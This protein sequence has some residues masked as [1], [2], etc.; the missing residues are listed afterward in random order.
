MKRNAILLI[1][2]SV[3]AIW[4][5]G[6]I[7]SHSP[8]D[9]LVTIK[10]GDSQKFS[11]QGFANGPYT[12]TKN[13][14]IVGNA[15]ASFT[16]DAVL[17]DLGTFS[18]KVS[19]KDSFNVT[20][21]F[22][23]TV[24]V[25][26]DLPPVANAGPDQNLIYPNPV[27]LDGSASLDPEG[28]PLNYVWEIVG[29]P[30]GSSAGLDDPNAENPIFVP[31]K[32]GA[33][34]IVLIVNDGRLTSTP[35]TVIINSYVGYAP[36]I[37]DAGID[38][39]VLFGS[40]VTLDGSNSSDPAEAELTYSWKIDS[41]P[42]E[43][44]ATLDDPTAQKP[45]FIPDKKGVYVVSLIV[46]NTVYNS[47]IDLVVIVV[48]NNP[49]IANAG[50]DTTIADLGGSTTLN[51]TESSDPDGTA[52]EYTWTIIS[53]PYGSTA[54]LS[55]P[56]IATP[57]FTP[58]KKGSYIMKL[59]VS[60]GDLLSN[61]D[62]VIVT[63][64][65][66]VPTA[67]AGDPIYL[68]LGETAQLNGSASDPDSDPMTYLWTITS[69]PSG[70]TAALSDATI[71]NPTFTPDVQGSYVFSLVATDNTG[72]ASAPSTVVISTNNHQPVADAGADVIMASNTS[73]LLDGSGT[74]PDS[75]PLTYKWRVISAPMGSGGDSTI[76]DVN[77]AKPTFT[78][79][80]RGDYVLG[81]IVNDGQVDSIESTMKVHVINNQPVADPGANKSAHSA[82]GTLLVVGLDGSASHDIDG[83][84]LTYK[85]RI[86]SKPAGS[87]AALSSTTAVNPTIT[88]NI[89]GAYVVGLTVNDGAIESAEVTV[90]V[91]YT[92]A[93]PTA[94]AGA[95]QSDHRAYGTP[96]IF[97]L[98]GGGSTD[99]D[100]DPL[101]YAWTLK[102]RPSGSTATI[103]NPTSQTPT[104]T[105][106]R[107]GAYVIGLVVGDGF[108]AS[109]E[110]T[111]TVNYTNS[112]P[113]ADAGTYAN[114]L[115]ANRNGITLNGGASSDPE[116]DP[117]S[118]AW[119]QTGGTTVTLNGANTATP[120][121]N[122]AAPG[123]YTFSL[124]VSDGW[125]TSGA[126]TTT[127][128]NSTATDTITTF[129]GPALFGWTQSSGDYT[130]SVG[131]SNALNHTSGGS[132]SF[133]TVSY[134]SGSSGRSGWGQISKNYP[135]PVTS[136]SIW[137]AWAKDSDGYTPN[138]KLLVNGIE[139]ATVTLSGS[140]NTW[141]QWTYNF[142]DTVTNIEFRANV[143]M[144]YYWFSRKTNRLYFDD[145][146]VNYWN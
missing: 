129:E 37:A 63:C 138:A 97:T 125:I 13:G 71:L 137:T 26:D 61:E 142:A 103:V 7:T 130:S 116:G 96:L 30:E 41:G 135:G 49:P 98:D 87:T 120:W 139:R 21:E 1:M 143:E 10:V 11:V 17:E 93:A 23:W 54:D 105:T 145:I 118:Y 40:E 121:F 90:T 114:V 14:T 45:K 20:N 65:N 108:A 106:D 82:Y 119:T 19:T 5:S 75:D 66:H 53:R 104:I 115:Y 100:S 134:N 58:D 42:A 136:V 38:Q 32:Q 128:V 131:T 140:Q 113:T 74:D 8:S 122:M 81:L 78:P 67:I 141:Q 48:Y 29:R 27:Q 6:C 28:Q 33:Y 15:S 70:S 95:N 57:N 2:L 43:S 86:I 22:V 68:N 76:S 64:S 31:D 62:T 117:L 107:P 132:Y 133:R 73:A 24:T 60:D 89:P 18:I 50:S 102:S 85:W 84:P 88:S 79:D 99:G 25:V 46:N 77:I 69:S 72:L 9:S 124:T 56:S 80:M 94:N 39:S 44:A 91:T 51:G 126:S 110:S 123:T 111:V 36:P 109:T 127:V 146:T 34:T 16:Y 144:R 55:N 112:G 4:L 59:I 83:D 92:N 12:W 52:L 101:G 35:D 47:G 3:M